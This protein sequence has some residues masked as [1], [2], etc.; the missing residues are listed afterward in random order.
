MLEFACIFG[1]QEQ[2]G[3]DEFL[4]QVT[5]LLFRQVIQLALDVCP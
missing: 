2:V 1:L 3:F 4:E 5:L